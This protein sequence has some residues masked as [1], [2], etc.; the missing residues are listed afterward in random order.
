MTE[1]HT[2]EKDA[3]VLGGLLHREVPTF[4]WE[5][6]EAACGAILHPYSRTT[7]DLPRCGDCYPG[8]TLVP[9]PNG[10]THASFIGCSE[11]CPKYVT[12]PAET[13]VES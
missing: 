1:E 2:A 13:Q 8:S 7:V 12:S 6:P 9:Y 11:G 5:L 3:P 10:H 4:R